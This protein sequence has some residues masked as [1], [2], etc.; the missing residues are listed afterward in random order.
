M[1]AKEYTSTL[2]SAGFKRYV[3]GVYWHFTGLIGIDAEEESCTVIA[4]DKTE[5]LKTPSMNEAIW[6]SI[7]LLAGAPAPTE[8]EYR[9]LIKM[10]GKVSTNNNIVERFLEYMKK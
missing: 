10:N 2:K 6:F 4:L 9:Q 8:R 3:N 7:D 1:L 5:L